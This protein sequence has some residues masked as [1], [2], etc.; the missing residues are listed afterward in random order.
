MYIYLCFKKHSW[1]LK[2]FFL[3]GNFLLFVI[4]L[5]NNLYYCYYHYSLHYKFEITIY[6]IF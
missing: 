4:S 3:E 6:I 5:I 2:K 1:I